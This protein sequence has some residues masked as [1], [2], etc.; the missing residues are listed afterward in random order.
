MMTTVAGVGI[1]R[2]CKLARN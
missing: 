2:N 1:I